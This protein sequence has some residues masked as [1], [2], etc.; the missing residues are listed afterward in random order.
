M[1][2]VLALLTKIASSSTFWVSVLLPLL[3]LLLQQIGID[4]P[5]EAVMAGQG[6]YGVK[7]AATKLQ[8][9]VAAKIAAAP[10]E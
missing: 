9:L 10:K 2:A 7:E 3:K 4:V 1:T 8:P 6:A 5:W